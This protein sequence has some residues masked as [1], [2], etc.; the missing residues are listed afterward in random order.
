MKTASSNKVI[1]IE[2]ATNK[3]IQTLNNY[4]AQTNE[5]VI[6]WETQY[7][8]L[9]Q[10]LKR[11]QQQ[12]MQHLFYTIQ[13]PE[14]YQKDM[15]YLLT[16]V[17][18]HVNH[19]DIISKLIWQQYVKPYLDDT[20][21]RIGIKD[22]PGIYKITYIQNNKC[23]VGKSTNVKKRIAD[24]FKSVIGIQSI[25]DQA[26]HHQIKN[27]GLWNWMIEVIGYFPKE[28]LSEKQKFYIKQFQAVQ[29]GF[30]KNSGG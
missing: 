21:K 2:Q 8:N 1:Q 20:F 13:I 4:V 26:V 16:T 10:P 5:K 12:K 19:P 28:E 29:Y 7:N 18:P 6:E 3:A 9:L 14:Q 23:Y 11:L 27:T 15:Q 30:N 22:Q 17:A 25:A 24:H